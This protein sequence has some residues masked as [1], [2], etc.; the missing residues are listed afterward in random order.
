MKRMILIPEDFYESLVSSDKIDG[1]GDGTALGLIKER[2]QN[3][4][5]SNNSLDPT[6]RA[7]RYEQD[8]KRYNKLIKEKEE[9]PIDVKL[10][11]FEEIADA[12]SKNVDLNKSPVET[13]NEINK[14]KISRKI[15]IRKPKRNSIG[16]VTLRKRIKFSNPA[17]KIENPDEIENEEGEEFFSADSETDPK[18]EAR[19]YLRDHANELGILPSGKLARRLGTQESF[20]TSN[21]EEILSYIIKNKGKRKRPIPTGYDEFIR[22]INSHSI[23]QNILFPSKSSTSNQEGEGIFKHTFSYKPSLWQN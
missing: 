22:R 16:K 3:S 11:N 19:Q 9:K 7:A 5:A 4:S 23:L 14:N 8:F 18:E 10:K 17:V 20:V 21:I 13:K 6:T 2:L 12:V 15:I 1:N